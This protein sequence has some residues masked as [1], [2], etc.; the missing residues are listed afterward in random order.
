MTPEEAKRLIPGDFILI[1]TQLYQNDIVGN[2]GYVMLRSRYINPNSIL[3]KPDPPRRKFKNG[4]I[5]LFHDNVFN[6]IDDESS[7]GVIIS[8]VNNKN[9]G[10]RV[11]PSDL[12]LVC[13]AENREDRKEDAV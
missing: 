7:D 8:I 1:E 2:D 10:N 3:K 4:D 9:H 13:A 12:T 11:D 5:V 6:V